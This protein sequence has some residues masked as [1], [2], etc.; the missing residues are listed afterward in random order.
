MNSFKNKFYF[1]VIARYHEDKRDQVSTIINGAGITILFMALY[2]FNA[3][4]IG[5]QGG[6]FI[7]LGLILAFSMSFVFLS[8]GVSPDFIGNYIATIGFTGIVILCFYTGGTTSP[9]FPWLSMVPVVSLLFSKPRWAG[10]WLVVDLL[11]ILL[12]ESIFKGNVFAEKYQFKFYDLFYLNSFI[13]L[14]STFFFMSLVYKKELIKTNDQLK[15]KKRELESE[16]QK[17]DAL[18]LNILPAEI[19]QNLIKDGKT[20][21][22]YY[23]N[24]SILFTD[25]V[26]FTKYCERI[27]PVELVDLL[28]HYF[29][30]FDQIMLKYGMEKI[31]TIGD[32][33]MAVSGLPRTDQD[34]ALHAV[35]AGI[36]ILE[37]INKNRSNGIPLSIRIGIHSGSAIAGII[38]T[39]KFAYDVWGDDV[40]MA[41]RMEQSGR[42]NEINISGATHNLIKDIIPCKYR[43][44]VNAKNKGEVDLY[45]VI[46]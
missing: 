14:V 1:T 42:I 6:V 45:T 5:F 11:F 28:H 19:A 18:L 40:N 41:A 30:A 15:E 36:E 13:G 29:K 31:K 37:C 10:G 21:A 4:W 38:G 2:I 16:K 46:I 8:Y 20:E 23:Q 34:H 12:S 3:V 9:V 32:A 44:K 22:Q 27:T 24:V 17:T 35:R 26:G 43:G 25:F 33:Y 7:Q 39:Q